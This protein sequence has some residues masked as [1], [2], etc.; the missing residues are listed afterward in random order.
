MNDLYQKHGQNHEDIKIIIKCRYL[1]YTPKPFA[2]ANVL[3]YFSIQIAL[4]LPADL[5][6][7]E[8]LDSYC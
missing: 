2:K 6:K 7:Q 8:L 5:K 3:V 4:V 1:L